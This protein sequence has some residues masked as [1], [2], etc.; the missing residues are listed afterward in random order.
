MFISYA[1]NLEDL[2]LWRALRSVQN[3]FYIDV[4]AWHPETDS[5]TKWFYDFGWSG[6]NIEPDDY[7]FSQLM[8]ARSRDVNLKLALSEAKGHRTLFQVGEAT[9]LSTLCHDIMESHKARGYTITEKQV[10]SSTLSSVCDEYA[11]EVIH[12]LKIDVEGAEYFVLQG[13]DFNRFRPWIILIEATVPLSLTPAFGN[14]EHVLLG[15]NYEYIYTDG[16]NRFYISSEKISDLKRAFS[17]PPNV[18]DD[19]VRANE[20]RFWL[21]TSDD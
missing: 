16:I 6:I 20:R 5:V 19:Y 15:A 3:G 8:T 21:A 7:M 9:G 4:G 10:L 17:F 2:L 14:W 11:P 12:F 1:Q 18:F 13:A